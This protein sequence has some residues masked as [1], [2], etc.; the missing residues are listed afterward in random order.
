MKSL[1][2]TTLCVYIN[3][4]AH[5]QHK[6]IRSTNGMF[7]YRM[8]HGTYTTYIYV[9]P[10]FYINLSVTK[11]GTFKMVTGGHVG[12]KCIYAGNVRVIGDTIVL[13]PGDFAKTYHE[14]GIVFYPRIANIVLLKHGTC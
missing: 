6:I 13:L 4:A 14:P 2:L 5:A 11:A 7:C 10:E 8:L 1:I 12:I 9:E 3:C